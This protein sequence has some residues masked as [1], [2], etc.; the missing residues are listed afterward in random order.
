M[1]GFTRLCICFLLSVPYSGYLKAQ[2]TTS[3]QALLLKTGEIQPFRVYRIS[4]Q[5]DAL[6]GVHLMGYLAKAQTLMITYDST[7]LSDPAIIITAVEHLNEGTCV[8]QL[9][10]DN[11]YAFIEQ[12]EQIYR[13][14]TSCTDDSFEAT[15][16]P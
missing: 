9:E 4:R 5:L 1:Q 7:L 14:E 11:L 12:T 15:W 10:C 3:R 8:S 2:E 16:S 6:N 13:M